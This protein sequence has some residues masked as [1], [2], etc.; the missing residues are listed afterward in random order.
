[1]SMNV[2]WYDD[3]ASRDP[4]MQTTRA[5]NFGSGTGWLSDRILCF[6]GIE[7]IFAI[8]GTILITFLP[9]TLLERLD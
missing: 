5:P 7:K 8:C 9:L 2:G 1:M 4:D 6:R 3:L